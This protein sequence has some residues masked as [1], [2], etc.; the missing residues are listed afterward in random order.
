[1]LVLIENC[2]RY[3][4]EKPVSF[5]PHRVRL[6]PRTDQAIVTHRL[7]TL[8]NVPAD[9]QY[10]RDLFDNLVANCFFPQAA[11]TLE[12][13][14]RLK[15][16]LWPKNPFHFLL[17]PRATEIPFEYSPAEA[18]VL[19]PFL[20][21]KPEEDFD[22]DHLWRFGTK[23]DT[24]DALVDLAKFLHNEIAYEVREDGDARLPA[25]T[26]ELR[27]G[28]CRDTAL[29]CATIMRKQGLAVRL[30]SGFLCDFQLDVPD[31]RPD[32]ALHAWIEVFL[33]GAGW[34]G[35]DPTNG[36]FCD[37]RF[38]PTAVGVSLP[39]VAPIEGSY[40][41]QEKVPG[42]FESKLQLS[43]VTEEDP[44]QIA[45]QV[46]QTFKKQDVLVTMG[47]EPT[48]VPENPEG[49]EWNFAAVGPTKLHYA[50]AFARAVDKELWPG[51]LLLYSPGKLY[52]GEVNPRWALHVLSPER[53]FEPASKTQ[54]SKPDE[55]LA[56]QFRDGVV[57]KLGLEDRWLKAVDPKEPKKAIWVLPLDYSDDRWRTEK[58]NLRRLELLG[59]EGPSGLRLPL[60]DLP[61]EALKRAM[62]MDVAPDHIDLFLPPLLSVP[63]EQ[64]IRVCSELLKTVAVNWQGYTP[65]DTPGTW[66]H[67][68]FSADPGVLEVNLPA[69]STW[70][71]YKKWVEQLSRIALSI[72]LRAHKESSTIF[73][74]GGGNHVLFGGI[75][76][77]QNP[78]FSRPSWLSSILRYWQRHPS[79]SY[80]FTGAYVG[81]SGQAPRPDESGQSPLDL[82]LA[83]RQLEKLPSGDQRDAISEIA[84]HLHTDSG[85]NPHRSEI[86]FDKFWSPPTGFLGLIEFRAV[87]SLP[88]TEWIA[89]VAL[90]FRAIAAYL[91]EKPYQT[92]LKDW[93]NNLHDR[94]FLPTPLWMDLT[95]VLT[96][97]AQF[98]VAFDPTIFR[99][100]WEWRFAGLLT[101]EGLTVRRALEAWP[102]LSDTPRDGSTTSRF[103]DTSM[104]RLEFAVTTEAYRNYAVY[105]NGRELPFRSL[106]PREL[107]AGLRYRA[108]A[109]YPSLHPKIPVQLPLELTLVN[110]ETDQPVR[111]FTLSAGETIFTEQPVSDLVRKAP[112]EPGVP[113]LM[114]C[115]L[116]IEESLFR[117][118]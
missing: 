22:P 64:L 9:I 95:D 109:L 110:R 20:T 86:S 58:W 77:Q 29:L 55:R 103:V 25:K 100:I 23:R 35:I 82:E 42:T 47:G 8:I 98:G 108:T 72:G 66:S 89:G 78:F 16:E 63:F 27:S 62:V 67:L 1:M 12:I 43:L 69:C 80:L 60:Q 115:D 33:P 88:Q 114:T 118:D 48:Y 57:Q 44:E 15:V 68:I 71:E 101:F 41:G 46:E 102:L 11:E 93:G 96:D 53:P 106:S 4:Y 40:F 30:V 87:E 92:S 39:D 37:H 74:T 113:E 34:V 2:M 59:A 112:L 116:R 21:V 18:K 73:G 52:P 45:E 31:R 26:L 99:Q 85:G 38:I 65:V 51:S 28:A 50:Y 79:L 107:V 97:L 94:F 17:A 13:R 32:S 5:S 3:S 111:R 54:D 81:P 49:P 76:L 19:E 105:I 24:V 75:T 10:R 7:E 90:L 14:S 117:E 36:T 56:K 83:Y 70:E 84:R 61:A 6:F 91:L 104:A